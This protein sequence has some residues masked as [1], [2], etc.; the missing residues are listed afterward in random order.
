MT[1]RMPSVSFEVR[2]QQLDAFRTEHGHCDV[3]KHY[4]N[5]PGLYKWVDG[6]RQRMR[7]GK[8]SE[9]V[10]SELT[11]RGFNFTPRLNRDAADVAQRLELLA[12]YRAQTG[13]N[14]PSK[15]DPDRS[16]AALSQWISRQRRHYAGGTLEPETEEL[17]RKAGVRLTIEHNNVTRAGW[18][19]EQKAFEANLQVLTA[20]LDGLTAPRQRRE[21][22]YRNIKDSPEASR[23]Y[24]FI[25][26]LV[27]KAR[28]GV[29]SDAHRERVIALNFL[30]SGKPIADVLDPLPSQATPEGIL[31]ARARSVFARADAMAREVA[32]RALETS[33][34]AER[35]VRQARQAVEI[36]EVFAATVQARKTRLISTLDAEDA[37]DAEN[38]ENAEASA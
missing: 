16:F 20:W 30:F 25:E 37:E 21:L 23:A 8:L 34:Q 15:S 24:R 18:A 33:L 22:A 12:R 29:L 36:A 10:I 19:G 28:Q 4:A 26:H 7:S 17:L 35:D 31:L 38:A 6:L 32:A 13:R 27:L 11:R 14:E 9:A 5:V 3:P 1:K 2:L